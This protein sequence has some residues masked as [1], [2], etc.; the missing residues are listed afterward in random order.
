MQTIIGVFTERIDADSAI[1]ELER[2]GYDAKDMSIVMKD[3]GEP[4]LRG[5]K[6]GSAA[7]GAVSGA[8]T[9]GIVGGLAGLLIG[10]GAL[11]IPGVGAF[12]IG[13]PIAAVLGLT[14][15]AAATVS[16]VATGI[17]AG[18]ILGTLVGLGIPE[19]DARVYEQRVRE[20]AVL[21]AV[22]VGNHD[23]GTKVR[24]IFDK[25][26]ADQVRSVGSL[27]YNAY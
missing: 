11:A 22:P 12:L 4:D 14:G 2:A 24:Q 27:E 17:V 10:V 3:T 15:A 25:Y 26:H 5:S 20:G 6:G 18:G 1:N 23:N 13:G 19:E 21:L 8:T 9:G 7:T 16:G